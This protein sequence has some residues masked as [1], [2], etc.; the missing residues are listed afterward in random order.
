MDLVCLKVR[1]YPCITIETTNKDRVYLLI[2]ILK[3][4]HSSLD[5]VKETKGEDRNKM[6]K[7]F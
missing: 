5:K 2:I 3:G 6:R 1:R 4:F 7:E